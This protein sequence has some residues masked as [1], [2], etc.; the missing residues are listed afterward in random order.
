M[1]LERHLCFCLNKKDK[2]S[3]G[4][5]SVMLSERVTISA[6]EWQKLVDATLTVRVAPQHYIAATAAV[7]RL[8]SEAMNW[9]SSKT[10]GE[11]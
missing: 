5:L 1:L 8:L 2:I 6:C 4:I 9:I 11:C 10:F 3:V 7:S